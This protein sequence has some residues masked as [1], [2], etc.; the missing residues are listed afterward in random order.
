MHTVFTIGHSNR[1][2]DE[3]I[4]LLP[5]YQILVLIDIRSHPASGRYPQFTGNTLRASLQAR[6]ILWL[7]TQQFSDFTGDMGKFILQS[8]DE[9]DHIIRLTVPRHGFNV[10]AET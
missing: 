1:T 3:L 4:D 5:Q 6:G 10:H 7:F 8:V 2:I 9:W